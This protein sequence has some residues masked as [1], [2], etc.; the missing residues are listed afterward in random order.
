MLTMIE[1]RSESVYKTLYIHR[2]WQHV[3]HCS[4]VMHPFVLRLQAALVFQVRVL[5]ADRKRNILF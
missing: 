5:F 2:G 4:F 1:L 3:A